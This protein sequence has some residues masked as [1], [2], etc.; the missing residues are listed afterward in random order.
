MKHV[1]SCKRVVIL[2]A[3]FIQAR[4]IYAR[5]PFPVGFLDHYHICQPIRIVYFFD[6]ARLL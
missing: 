5:S 6:E 3:S 2:W 1:D 4:E